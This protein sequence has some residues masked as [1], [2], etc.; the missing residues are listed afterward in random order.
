MSKDESL[1]RYELI[2]KILSSGETPVLYF[3]EQVALGLF[4][5]FKPMPVSEIGGLTKAIPNGV[6]V[7]YPEAYDPAIT[8]GSL[9]TYHQ[10]GVEAESIKLLLTGASRDVPEDILNFLG[11]TELDDFSGTT[12]K[13]SLAKNLLGKLAGTGVIFE[14]RPRRKMSIVIDSVLQLR[15]NTIETL[16]KAS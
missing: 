16:T 12:I 13:T 2:A 11:I 6:L 4:D 15:P 5:K 3:E 10:T 8:I 9:V 7:D 14:P 1:S